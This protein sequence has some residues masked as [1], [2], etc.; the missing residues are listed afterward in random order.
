MG[1]APCEQD[2][3]LE[4]RR[5]ARGVRADDQLR[6]GAELGLERVVR[7]ETGDGQAAEEVGLVGRPVD[8][9][10]L[11]RQEVVRSGM[12]TWT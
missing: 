12:T 8:G 6:T 1:A 11:R 3:P 9:E 4:E 5:L 7:A 2:D 10:C